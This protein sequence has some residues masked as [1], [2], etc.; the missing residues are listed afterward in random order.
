MRKVLFY[1]FLLVLLTGCGGGGGDTSS[2][3]GGDFSP[4]Y[5]GTYKGT[6]IINATGPGGSVSTPLPVTIVVSNDGR[7]DVAFDGLTSGG[8]SCTGDE[9]PVFINGNSFN[10]SA[11]FT[12]QF[13]DLGS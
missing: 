5:I 10:E 13:P 4:E 1:L 8:G 7:V 12:C 6:L 3:G 11:T 9:S 2:G